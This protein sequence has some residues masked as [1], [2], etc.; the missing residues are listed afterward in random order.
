M[1]KEAIEQ[2]QTCAD[3]DVCLEVCP[4]YKLTGEE[5]FSPRQRLRTAAVLLEGGDIDARMME[6]I[7]NCPKCTRC[8]SVCP[9]QIPV[10]RIIHQSREVL[11][12]QGK[13]PLEQHQKIIDGIVKKRNA[14]NGDPSKRLDWLPIP[15]STNQSDTLLYLGCLPSYLVKDAAASSYLVLK[16]LGFDFM[17]LDDEGCCGTYLYESGRTDLAG[18][19]FQRNVERFASLGI[20]EI[21]VPCNGCLKCFKTF[22]PDLL[23]ETSFKTRHVVQVVYQLLEQR[24][25]ISRKI[26]RTVTYHDPCRLARGEGITEEPRQILRACG[27]EVKDMKHNRDQTA[28][29]GSG[30]GIRSVYRNLSTELAVDMLNEVSTDLVVSACPFCTFNINYTAA[31]KRIDKSAVYITRLILEALE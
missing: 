30:G 27:V 8:E 5:L 4:T 10:T 16:K 9:E 15:R 21:I 12:K 19:F 3:C 22:Y 14:V 11:A 23:G 20:R 24:P 28:C 26:Q 1:T 13:G 31:K 6:S 2:I 7:Y 25:D 18:E 29:C 17:I